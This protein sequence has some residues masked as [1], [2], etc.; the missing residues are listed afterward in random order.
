M[1]GVAMLAA[2]AK[3]DLDGELWRSS[4]QGGHRFAAT[5]LYLP[6]GLHYG[7]LI[8]EE[9]ELLLAAHRRGE[10]FD[11]RRYRGRCCWS[12]PIQTAEA[13]LRTE[14]E[15]VRFGELELL[16]HSL[17]EEDRWT[18]RFR[19]LNGMLHKV[20]VEPRNTETPTKASCA[21][22]ELTTQLFYYVVRHEAQ[23]T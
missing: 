10:L 23:I 9:A 20:T 7:R 17:H 1:R 13:W 15:A 22:D 16:S 21:S 14:L 19:S 11:L 2:L 6:R 12:R 3:R 18:V 8:P 5:M 4:H